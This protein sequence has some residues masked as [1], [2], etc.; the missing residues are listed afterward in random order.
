MEILTNWRHKLK[1]NE[2]HY[3]LGQ[4]EVSKLGRKKSP[5]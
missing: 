2:I 1:K 4:V 5:A 3:Y